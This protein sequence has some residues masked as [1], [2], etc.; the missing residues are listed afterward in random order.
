FTLWHYRAALGHDLVV[1]SIGNSL[2]YVALSTS[3]D[4]V[5]G[6]AIA[7]VAVRGRGL[8]AVLLDAAAMLPLAVPGL[9]LAFG[10][11]AIS[12]EGRPLAALNPARDPTFLLV[13]AYAVRRLPFV[14][15]SASAG[16]QQIGV[17]LEEAARNIGASA[18][19]VFGR[20]SL[21]LLGPHLLA[22]AVFA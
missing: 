13:I 20:V 18:L 2:R 4:L 3:L 21:P 6:V 7:Y 19:R 11:L 9:V 15:R 16:F 8:A 17:V 12:R 5:L 22:G 14:V 1:P 10:Y